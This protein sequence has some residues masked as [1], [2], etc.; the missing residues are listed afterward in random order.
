M[1]QP[2][3]SNMY[4]YTVVHAF[5][6]RRLDYSCLVFVGLHLSLTAH[7]DWV[8]CS[9]AYLIGSIANY[10]PISS[11]TWDTLHWLPIQ[12]CICYRMAALVLCCLLGA[13][14][15]YSVALF[16]LWLAVEHFAKP[17]VVSSWFPVWAPR[18]CIL[19]CYSFYLEF[20][21]LRASIATKE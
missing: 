20:I 8:Y 5:V 21:P 13:A 15:I 3:A 18:P 6:T 12:Q 4:S 19:D 7:L 14:L 10:A 2:S 11:Y 16:W 1:H 9:V 17:L